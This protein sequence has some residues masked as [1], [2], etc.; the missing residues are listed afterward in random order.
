[1]L[2][3]SD[4]NEEC[5]DGDWIHLAQN[6]IQWQTIVNIVMNLQIPSKAGL[7]LSSGVRASL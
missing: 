4:I 5:E 6:K 2:V 1:M 3:L 7:P